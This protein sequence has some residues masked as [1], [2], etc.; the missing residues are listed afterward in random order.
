MV[1]VGC[2]VL[3]HLLPNLISDVVLGMDLLHNINPW[4]DWSAYLL[5][6]D[7]EGHTVRI[8][9]SPGCY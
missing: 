1:H 3:Y 7:C 2:C 8:G 5:S 4:I 9:I 6:L